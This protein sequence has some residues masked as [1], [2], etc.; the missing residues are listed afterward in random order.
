MVRSRGRRI[1]RTR[2][3]GNGKKSNVE[4]GTRTW[5][6]A[7]VGVGVGAG[8]RAGAD[9]INVK[10]LHQHGFRLISFTKKNA[11]S[12]R[13][14]KSRTQDTLNLSTCAD[15]SANTCDSTNTVKKYI[16]CNVSPVTCH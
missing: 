4:L 8:A 11:Y 15:S 3:K 14:K 6:G 9:A 16:Y 1:K 7:G 12:K 2:S 5:E 10:N 13:E